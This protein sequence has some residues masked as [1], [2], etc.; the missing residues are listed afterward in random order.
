MTNNQQLPLEEAVYQNGR[1]KSP[2]KRAM[3]SP[4]RKS[5]SRMKH[6]AGKATRRENLV[7][8]FC[9]G[10]RSTARTGMLLDQ[11][12]EFFG[13]S[14]DLDVLRPAK[15]DHLLTSASQALTPSPDF[16]RDGAVRTA[17]PKL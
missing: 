2:E 15:P 14:L 17:A 9:A 4:E 11:H 6:S 10:T 13:C 3:W 7:L 12:R 1:T 16:T 5:L 8:D